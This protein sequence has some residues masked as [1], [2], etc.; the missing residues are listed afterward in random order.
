MLVMSN[1]KCDRNAD[2]RI[3]I[4]IPEGVGGTR[5]SHDV[6]INFVQ[7]GYPAQGVVSTQND[8]WTHSLCASKV[9]L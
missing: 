9:S 5:S 8:F 2:D 3:I 6:H 1:G 7:A 4:S